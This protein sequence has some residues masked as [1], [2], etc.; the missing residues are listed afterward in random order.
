MPVEDLAAELSLVQ[1]VATA[2]QQLTQLASIDGLI[3]GLKKDMQT[4]MT[5]DKYGDGVQEEYQKWDKPE[6]SW[7]TFL[8]DTS[9]LN[10]KA[11][12]VNDQFPVD[13][14]LAALNQVNHS[15]TD[16]SYYRLQAET[17]RASRAASQYEFDQIQK[18]IDYQKALEKEAEKTTDLKAS[19]DLQNKLQI[20]NNLI[21][22]GM[23]RQLSVLNQQKALETQE[24]VN[25]IYENAS[26]LQK[27]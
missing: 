15:N 12:E 17:V 8:E 5:G 11:K 22:L 1:Q 4:Y 27:K 3:G 23:L 14:E 26:F 16:Q 21:L 24:E 9:G 10:G 19:V 13:K 2:A 18:D 20:E 25:S 6:Q 7:D